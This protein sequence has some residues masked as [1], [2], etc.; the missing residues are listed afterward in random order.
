MYSMFG[1]LCIFGGGL[2]LTRP[3][4]CFSPGVTDIYFGLKSSIFVKVDDLSSSRNIYQPDEPYLDAAPVFCNVTSLYAPSM[5][6]E[7]K[8]HYQK[9]EFFSVTAV[10]GKC[11]RVVWVGCVRNLTHLNPS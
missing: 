1:G 10:I 5:N 3:H 9:H 6:R 8:L 2:D 11:G 7:K 4:R